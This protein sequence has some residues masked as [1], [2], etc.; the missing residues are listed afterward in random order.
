MANGGSHQAQKDYRYQLRKDSLPRLVS[1]GDSW[2]DYPVWSN[3][4]DL[5]D[6]REQFAVRRL[7]C[8]GDKLREIVAD[9]S[10][11][12]AIRKEKPR[13]LLFSAGG[14]DFVNKPFVTGTDKNSPL[15]TKY[16]ADAAA[17]ELVNTEKWE[18]KLDEILQMYEEVIANV[19][20]QVPI[21]V[22]GYDYIIPSL[23]PAKYDGVAVAG[24]W[25][26]PTMEAMCIEDEKL[27]CEIGK[28]LI[29]SFNEVLASLASNH[30]GQFVHVDLRTKLAPHLWANEIH[31]YK[32]GFSILADA[33]REAISQALSPT[34][35]AAR[36]V[37]Q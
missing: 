28:L 11:L 12:T 18:H 7:E 1:E 37:V 23:V 27:Q 5:V 26:R 31:P 17:E 34:P 2:F 30:P 29:D 22:H 13:L 19:G 20:G 4:I 33:Y 36:R 3:I 16:F 9:G 25:I 8:S 10:Y 15:F 14:N 35:I 21:L 24:P 6:E 32:Q